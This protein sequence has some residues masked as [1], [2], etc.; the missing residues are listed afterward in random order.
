MPDP[1][2]SVIIPCYNVEDL[3]AEAIDS[4]LA[5]T[6]SPIEIIVVDDGSTDASSER[7]QP[8]ADDG[9]V[10]LVRQENAGP[11]AA[12]NRGIAEA[13]G[14]LIAFLD[15]D[16]LWE[17]EKLSRQAELFQQDSALGLVYA[18]RRAVIRNAD[19]NWADD[20]PRNQAIRSMAHHRGRIFREVV[21]GAFIALS[22]AVIPAEVLK[23]D[24]GFCEDLITTEDQHLYARIAHDYPIDYVDDEL[25]VMRRHGGNISWDPAREPQT[26]ESL[27]KI[28]AKFPDCSL[29]R[30]K[31]MRSTYARR[32]HFSA[33]EAFHDGRLR[34]A[35][36]EFF[37]ACKYAPL[38]PLNW[39]YLAASLLP[40]ALV[41]LIRALKQRLRRT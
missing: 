3:V 20:G 36:R 7:V 32:A 18:R 38:N 26:L 39:L 27:R 33:R 2:V 16:D 11:A 29:K 31:W 37:E 40:G 19:G 41:C 14:E 23:Q 17:P 10:T 30:C 12:R 13:R 8:F 24:G 28:A 25:V 15:A 34:Q 6:H 22:S 1:L 9:R 35:R 21:E 5:Q 4:A